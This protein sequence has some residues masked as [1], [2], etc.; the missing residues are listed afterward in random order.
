MKK[1]LYLSVFFGLLAIAYF[2]YSSVNKPPT[3]NLSSQNP[4]DQRFPWHIQQLENKA[5]R[6]FNI[7][8]AETTFKQAGDI[9]GKNMELGVII[10]PDNFHRLEMYYP[11]FSAGAITGKLIILADAEQAEL[12]QL[13]EKHKNIEQLK[14]GAR[15][16]IPSKE[17]LETFNSVLV[18]QLTLLPSVNLDADI[19]QQRFG[20]ALEIIEFNERVS[21]YSYPE[22]GLLIAL[23][24]ESKDVLHY[25]HP[26]DMNS[27]IENIKREL[28]LIETIN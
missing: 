19:I 16:F 6:V 12:I 28:K 25:V 21:F 13:A 18:K 26:K 22:K 8:L 23:Y 7:T 14:S 2:F 15:K 9:L 5:T 20:K 4:E 24:P 10:S 3:D 11:S 1:T 17:E 27:L